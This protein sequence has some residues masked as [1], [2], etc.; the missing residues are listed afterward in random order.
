MRDIGS[1]GPLFVLADD[2]RLG[3]PFPNVLVV[4][5]NANGLTHTKEAHTGQ[6]ERLGCEFIAWASD[7]C[8]KKEWMFKFIQPRRWLGWRYPDATH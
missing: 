7:T 8:N 2:P 6:Q 4:L 1:N 5:C 3:R